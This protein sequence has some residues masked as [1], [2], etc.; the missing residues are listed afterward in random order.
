MS[1]PEAVQLRWGGPSGDPQS[2]ALTESPTMAAL[3]RIPLGF[4]YLRG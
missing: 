2:P 3:N 4:E 1:D